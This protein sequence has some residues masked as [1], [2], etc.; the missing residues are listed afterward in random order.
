MAAASRRRT[1][2]G[3]RGGTDLAIFIIAKP[4]FAARRAALFFKDER[5]APQ[6]SAP[7]LQVAFYTLCEF[8]T[9][10]SKRKRHK[11]VVEALNADSATAQIIYYGPHRGR[12]LLI[13]P[14]LHQSGKTRAGKFQIK[15]KTRADRMRARFQHRRGLVARRERQESDFSGPCIIGYGSSPSRCGPATAN[16]VPVRPET[17]Q[18][19]MRSFCK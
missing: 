2:F 7:P 5:F 1:T 19:P 13:I 6:F 10:R 8:D 3:S 11:L 12:V 18:L 4:P 17:S 15:R 9:R 16:A 14:V